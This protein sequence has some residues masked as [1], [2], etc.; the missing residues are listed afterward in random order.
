MS[1]GKYIFSASDFLLYVRKGTVPP[2]YIWP[3]SLRVTQ[4]FKLLIQDTVSRSSSVLPSALQA[5]SV[6]AGSIH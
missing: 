6:R 4:N 5:A 1:L 2:S 3:S